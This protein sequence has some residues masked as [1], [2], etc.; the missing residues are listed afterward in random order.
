MIKAAITSLC[1]IFVFSAVHAQNPA[2][3]VQ[4]AEDEAVRRQADTIN[5]RK[6]L[7]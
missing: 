6:K 2:A 3:P 5:L 7:Q 4:V 1:V